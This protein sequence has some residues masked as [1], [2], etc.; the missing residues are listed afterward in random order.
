M[1]YSVIKEFD[2][3]NCKGVG[4][5]I[6]VSGCRNHCK[7]CFQ[8]ETWAFDYGQ[9]YTKE[10]EEYILTLLKNPNI[11][12]FSF[13]GGDPFE[14]ENLP[15]VTN[16]AQS[17]RKTFPDKK[18]YAWTGKKFEDFTEQDLVFA[19]ILDYLIDG[20]YMEENRCL[21]VPLMGS[22]NQRI[23]NSKQSVVQNKAVEIDYEEI[24][25]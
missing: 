5:S 12:S 4:A 25:M 9:P 14:P 17:I 8:P 20:P 7:G 11:K 19:N 10:T 15:I 1:N 18:L 22:T 13:L 3:A 16:L 23:L 24:E 6:F 21:E 2:V